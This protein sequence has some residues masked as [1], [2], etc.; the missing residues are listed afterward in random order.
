MRAAT[1]PN[2]VLSDQLGALNN[3]TKDNILRGHQAG[4]TRQGHG[5]W[6]IETNSKT[7]A[8][9]PRTFSMSIVTPGQE[10]GQSTG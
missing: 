10:D 5:A 7:P 2:G 1:N 8:F 6:A 9:P 3:I 4:Q